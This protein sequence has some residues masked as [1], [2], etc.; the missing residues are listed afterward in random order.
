MSTNA[1]KQNPTPSPKIGDK[2][3]VKF[4]AGDGSLESLVAYTVSHVTENPLFRTGREI[5]LTRIFKSSKIYSESASD[6]ITV[7]KAKRLYIGGVSDKNYI[8]LF[9]VEYVNTTERG[10]IKT[11]I[12]QS[13]GDRGRLSWNPE[14]MIK[15]AFGDTGCGVSFVSKVFV[16]KV[17]ANNLSEI[18]KNTTLAQNGI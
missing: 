18:A 11:P 16:S 2:V 10:V 4:V 15:E 6:H 17:M 9:S 3:T 5:K 12:T 8:G 1:I 14:A 7:L 13:S